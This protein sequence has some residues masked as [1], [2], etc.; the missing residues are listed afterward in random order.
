[1]QQVGSGRKQIWKPV[2][3]PKFWWRRGKISGFL[4]RLLAAPA[5]IVIVHWAGRMVIRCH[6]SIILVRIL[7]VFG[8]IVGRQKEIQQYQLGYTLYC[9]FAEWGIH[10]LRNNNHNIGDKSR[11]KKYILSSLY[12]ILFVL[13]LTFPADFNRESVLFIMRAMIVTRLSRNCEKSLTKWACLY[14]VSNDR[15]T[16]LRFSYTGRTVKRFWKSTMETE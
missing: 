13:F 16:N 7:K 6:G 5:I 1:M 3:D 8:G 11:R 10:I 9:F 4:R 12:F 15:S 2:S 14:W